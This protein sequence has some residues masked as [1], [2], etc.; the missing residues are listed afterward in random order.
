MNKSRAP[1]W[2]A[3][4]DLYRRTEEL[5]Q[6]I[7]RV[8]A[9]TTELP[10]HL[11]FYLFAVLMKWSGSTAIALERNALQKLEQHLRSDVYHAALRIGSGLSELLSLSDPSANLTYT[12]IGYWSPIGREDNRRSL[13]HCIQPLSSEDRR[14][15]LAYAYCFYA[16]T[17]AGIARRD[18]PLV[19]VTQYNATKAPD[20]RGLTAEYLSGGDNCSDKDAWPIKQAAGEELLHFL[21]LSSW[22]EKTIASYEEK[23]LETALRE[24]LDHTPLSDRIDSS[25]DAELQEKTEKELKD[26]TKDK[27]SEFSSRVLNLPQKLRK[28]VELSRSCLQRAFSSGRYVE[29]APITHEMACFMYATHML[30]QKACPTKFTYTFTVPILDPLGTDTTCTVTL[31]ISARIKNDLRLAISRKVWALFTNAL[32]LDYS[33]IEKRRLT[34]DAFRTSS[35]LLGHNLPSLAIAPSISQLVRVK[36][37]V[38]DAIDHAEAQGE[39][40]GYLSRLRDALKRADMAI[41]AIQHYEILLT[42]VL[43]ATNIREVF[44]PNEDRV[45]VSS[46]DVK[47]DEGAAPFPLS[48]LFEPLVNLVAMHKERYACGRD[49]RRVLAEKFSIDLSGA[50]AVYPEQIVEQ[51]SLLREALFNLVLNSLSTADSDD[52]GE[53]RG[54]IKVIARIE[55]ESL[56]IDV[57]DQYG[58]FG[59]ELADL[60]K[61][62]SRVMETVDEHQ[63]EEVVS[64]LAS[65]KALS[66]R[67]G[68]MGLGL[69][70][71]AAYARSREWVRSGGKSGALILGPTDIDNGR[72]ASVRLIVPITSTNAGNID[73]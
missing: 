55:K 1:H 70:F 19:S 12:A 39:P 43:G 29:E 10:P 61:E 45:L 50:E 40:S 23:V 35:R 66:T 67:K 41:P 7:G 24:L 60:K 11:R 36:R 30:W 72:G 28:E 57:I 73:R 33:D 27:L 49:D 59:D 62:V 58:G 9:Q 16:L 42:Y 64:E 44:R 54:G 17:F 68:S 21:G 69:V 34:A 3:D 26:S 56:I 38:Q 32:I 22:A 52:L 63:F 5:V 13:F 31:G 51:R 2:A 14:L 46:D 25:L 48:D 71:C 47:K 8:F 37:S 4:G 53:G 65:Q 18:K 6:E 15:M 20:R